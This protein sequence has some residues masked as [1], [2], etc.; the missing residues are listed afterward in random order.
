MNGEKFQ[1]TNHNPN[2]IP[3]A[4]FYECSD[5]SKTGALGGLYVRIEINGST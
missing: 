4:Q 2:P 1:K 3:S 5:A